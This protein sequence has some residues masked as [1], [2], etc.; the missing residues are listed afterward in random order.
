M[1]KERGKRGKVHSLDS[2]PARVSPCEEEAEKRHLTGFPTLSGRWVGGLRPETNSNVP[3]AV[4]FTTCPLV[5]VR[6]ELRIPIPW[7]N[8]SRVKAARGVEQTH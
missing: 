4:P 8:D 5:V 6:N 1:R 7:D 2:D 3:S